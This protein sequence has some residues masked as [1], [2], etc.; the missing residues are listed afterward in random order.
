MTG[1]DSPS[2]FK[3]LSNICFTYYTLKTLGKF[4]NVTVFCRTDPKK[5]LHKSNGRH[6]LVLPCLVIVQKKHRLVALCFDKIDKNV[7]RQYHIY[8]TSHDLKQEMKN[9]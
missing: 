7:K 4:N 5:I 9:S 6:L 2:D 8:N 1:A 3:G